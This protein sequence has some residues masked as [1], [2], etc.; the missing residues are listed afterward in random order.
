MEVEPGI[1][2]GPIESAYGLH[3][4][5]VQEKTEERMAESATIRRRAFHELKRLRGEE[6]LRERLDE[7]RGNYEIRVEEKTAPGVD[8]AS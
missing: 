1:W 8:N 5:W 7:I 2:S 3:L 6:R 4:V